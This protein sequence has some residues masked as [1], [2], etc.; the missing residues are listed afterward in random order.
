MNRALPHAAGPP[1]PSGPFRGKIGYTRDLSSVTLTLPADLRVF[2]IGYWALI[3][4]MIAAQVL[5]QPG[6]GLPIAIAVAGVFIGFIFERG[7][8]A[9]AHAI[10]RGSSS[11]RHALAGLLMFLLGLG[12]PMLGLAG[13]PAML[14]GLGL[15]Y[16]LVVRMSGHTPTFKLSDRAVT[17]TRTRMLPTWQQL[18]SGS[19]RVE[20]RVI[21][22][23]QVQDVILPSL[24]TPRADIVMLLSSGEAMPVW[25]GP[26]RQEDRQWLASRIHTHVRLRKERLSVEGHD[27]SKEA[28]LPDALQSIR[29]NT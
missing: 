8:V 28:A 9:L 11:A 17:M 7:A 6:I 13:M 3:L 29:E 14:L 10:S 21:P 18:H 25:T 16:L 27:L 22:L 24:T 2:R 23:E 12:V 19:G 20:R 5:G 1:A 26:L 4:P 15:L